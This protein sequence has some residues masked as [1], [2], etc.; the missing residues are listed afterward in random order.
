MQRCSS[1]NALLMTQEGLSHGPGVLDAFSDTSWGVSWVLPSKPGEMG[2]ALHCQV[3]VELR[4]WMIWIQKLGKRA[5]EM[6]Q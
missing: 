6:A 4:G 1:Y 2:A 5:G 3:F